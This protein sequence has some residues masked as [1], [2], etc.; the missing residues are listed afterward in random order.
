MWQVE[1]SWAMLDKFLVYEQ[2]SAMALDC[3]KSTHPVSTKVDNPSQI[4]EVFDSISYSKGKYR[5]KQLSRCRVCCW[6][7]YL[8]QLQR[9]SQTRW[10]MFMGFLSLMETILNAGVR[11]VC[12]SS[13][14]DLNVPMDKWLKML[15][16]TSKKRLIWKRELKQ[17]KR[18]KLY[19]MNENSNWFIEKNNKY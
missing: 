9:H 18:K 4:S 16:V 17:K 19:N 10:R 15:K 1:P 14:C 11:C 6:F 5:H 8:L 12:I 3:L 7:A 13:H 2:Q